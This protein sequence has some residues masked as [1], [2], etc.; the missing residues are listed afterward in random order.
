MPTID[1]NCDLGEGQPTDAEVLPFVTSA[2]VAC[3]LHAGGPTE[4]R[5]TVDEA[6]RLGV[7]VGAHPGFADRA[8]FGRVERPLPPDEIYDLVAYQTAALEAFTR[9]A[10]I[11]LAHVK[12]HGALYHLAGRRDDIADAIARAVRETSAARILVGAPASALEPAA[13]RHG[14]L[15][16]AEG[17]ADRGYTDDGQLVPRGREGALI[18]GGDDVVAARAVTLVREG[19]VPTASG[20]ELALSIQTLCLHGD[21][22]RVVGRARAVRQALVAAGVQ[23]APLAGWW[24]GP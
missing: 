15:F 5:R 6:A 2:N 18:S 9:R 4:M 16:A 22:P 20:G 17:F 19:R 10:Q 13:V 3:G 14:L 7:A 11:R 12:A 1:L 23:V 21:D 8:E 24:Q